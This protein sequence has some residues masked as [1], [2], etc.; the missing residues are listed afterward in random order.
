MI[1][2]KTLL[3]QTRTATLDLQRG[4]TFGHSSAR[5]A[6]ARRPRAECHGPAWSPTF[7]RRGR[8]QRCSKGVRLA[9]AAP[10]PNA[11]TGPIGT[12]FPDGGNFER[13]Q[14]NGALDLGRLFGCGK[15]FT[16][17][18]FIQRL[19]VRTFNHDRPHLPWF[20]GLIRSEA[21]FV[22][23]PVMYSGDV[24]TGV[25]YDKA[26]GY[27]R[28][29][30]LMS[31]FR[32]RDVV[33]TEGDGSLRAPINS[34]W[35]SFA[36]VAVTP[37]EFGDDWDSRKLK[38]PLMIQVNGNRLGRLNCG[39]DMANNFP[40]LIAHAARTHSL[41]AG[42]IIGSGTI[43]NKDPSTGFA[44]IAEQ[45]AIEAAEK[46]QPATPYLRAGDRVRLDVTDASGQ[47]VFGAIDQVIAIG[48]DRR[49]NDAPQ[50]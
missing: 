41:G 25:K 10:G 30:A 36:P 9:R 49:N 37:D 45:R 3:R 12:A 31:D 47:S 39:T 8:N 48:D 1:P 20:R 14:A 13:H 4:D 27:I 2:S 6:D 28:L 24:P 33:S 23:L 44:C 16:A 32:L 15:L 18:K 46:G 19:I 50:P 34:A 35:T 22:A 43:S 38:L 17:E 26:S 21:D 11:T 42:T 29:V 7:K 40:R 5:L